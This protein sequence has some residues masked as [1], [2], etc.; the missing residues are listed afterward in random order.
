MRRN[1][2]I[3]RGLKAAVVSGGWLEGVAE[4]ENI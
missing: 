4:L 1:P 2:Y 3:Q